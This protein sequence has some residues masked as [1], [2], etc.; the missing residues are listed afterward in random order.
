MNG[1]TKN[2]LISVF[3][4]STFVLFAIQMWDAI[5]PDSCF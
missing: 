1:I 4:S 3:I 5:G 2:V